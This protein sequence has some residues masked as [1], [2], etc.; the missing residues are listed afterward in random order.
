MKTRK[1][2][3]Y[4]SEMIMQHEARGIER[5]ILWISPVGTDASDE[6]MRELFESEKLPGTSVEVR[7]LRRGPHHLEY[8]YYGALVLPDVLHMLLQAEQEGFDAAILGCFYDPGLKEAREVLN[9]MPVI[10]PAETCS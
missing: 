4:C 1:S 10:F 5:R 6:A 3:G 2:S 7:S 9:T 8:H